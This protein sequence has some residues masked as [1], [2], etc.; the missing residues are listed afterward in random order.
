MRTLAAALTLL[1]AAAAPSA[2]QSPAAAP[3]AAAAPAELDPEQ[4]ALA[5]EVVTLA[6]PPERRQAMFA[7]VMESMMAQMRSAVFDSSGLHDPGVEPILDRFLA[8]IQAQGA[9]SIAAA[10]PALFK[11]IARAYA[12]AFT[13]DELIQIRTF[14]AT[15]TGAKYLQRSSEMLSDPDVAKA[16]TDYMQRFLT[17]VQPLQAEFLREVTAYYEK[18]PPKQ[19]R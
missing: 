17:D 1:L 8:R 5:E 16:N 2:A 18:H 6:F 4:V 11:A 10:S 12:R 14:I 7:S 13:R 3:A 15:P 9:R 19:R